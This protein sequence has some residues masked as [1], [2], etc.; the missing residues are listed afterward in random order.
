MKTKLFFFLILVFGLNLTAVTAQDAKTVAAIRTE[1]NAINK[2]ASKL[3][4]KTKDVEGISLEGTEADF[5]SD[6]GTLRKINARIYG[7]TYLA[8]AELYFKDDELIFAFYKH[9]R[10]DTQIGLDKPPKVVKVEEKRFY[11]A[12]N[13]LI[14]L[15]VGKINI[16]TGSKQW[17]NSES[18]IADWSKKLKDAFS[19]AD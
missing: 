14:K 19:A 15:L 17:E 6:G 1:V 3:T 2:G 10:Y 7:E 13:K 12:D 11:Y 18:D 5:F 9:S 16:K 4:K 8:T